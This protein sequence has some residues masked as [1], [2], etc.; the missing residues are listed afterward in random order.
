MNKKLKF[1]I[2]GCGVIAATHV[3]AIAEVPGAELYACADIS[4]PLADSFA[5]KHGIKSYADFDALISE[6]D[7]DV[8]C[9]CTPNGTHS[10]LAV[11]AIS[12]GKHVVLEKPMAI[13][14]DECEEIIRAVK[15]Y[16]AKITVI[17]QM[18][19]SPDIIK[20]KK[21]IESGVIGRVIL[22][23]LN[24]CYYRSGDYY[25]GSWRGTK[26]MDGGGALMN[27]GIHGVD[28]ILHLMGDVK[29]VQSIVRT[30]FHDIEVEDSAV[31]ALEFENGAL[32]VITAS[33]ATHPGFDR[34]IKIYGTRGAVFLRE[35]R[36]VKIVI[37][38]ASEP[39]EEFVSVGGAGTNMLLDH[40]GHAR[41]IS[42]FVKAING[43]CVKYPDEYD[44]K[45]AVEI[46]EK[47]YKKTI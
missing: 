27:Q 23:E 19:T 36:L 10:Q 5:G 25:R 40:A 7:I 42:D 34:E 8:V 18:R 28:L 12:A 6:N 41:Q 43:E 16:Q 21:M 14:S 31:A 26:S 39:C 2:Y 46:I 32:G 22:A 9:I 45:K 35:D 1:A 17:S 38:G 4:Q 47:I 15:K 13:S 24:M 11:K 37:D 30:L 44:G 3:K 29:N 20:A 33:T